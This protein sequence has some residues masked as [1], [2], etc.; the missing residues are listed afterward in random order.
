MLH[1]KQEMNLFATVK[2]QDLQMHILRNEKYKYTFRFS[3]KQ[4]HAMENVKWGLIK[5]SWSIEKMT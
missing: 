5:N 1:K 3:G 4:F 2:F